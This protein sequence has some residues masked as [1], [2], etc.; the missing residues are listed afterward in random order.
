MFDILRFIRNIP[1]PP[2][3]LHLTT[4]SKSYP[5]PAGP[6]EV[7]R[8]GNLHV[9]AGELIVITGQPLPPNDS[10]KTDTKGCS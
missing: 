3:V 4:I 6:V 5:S 7:L 2:P 8:A 1:M 10:V 9:N